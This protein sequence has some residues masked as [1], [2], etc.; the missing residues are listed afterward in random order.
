MDLR[1]AQ[2][3]ELLDEANAA[4]FDAPEALRSAWDSAQTAAWMFH[5]LQL[6]GVS[7]RADDIQ[8]ALRDEQ[9]VDYCDGVLL[10]Q[11]RRTFA[12]L[13]DVRR[14]GEDERP[15]SLPML[16]DW[17]ARL[18]GED[19]A[20]FRQS[21]GATEH[22][23]HDVG[24]PSAIIDDARVLF[25]STQ[26]RRGEDHPIPVA[27][28]LLFGL[29]KIWPYPTWS[30]MCAR[31]AASAVLIGQGYPPLVIP[32]RERVSFYQ[33]MHYDPSRMETLM[34]ACLQR[35]LE[36]KRDVMVGRATLAGLT[37]ALANEP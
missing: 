17:Q 36:A 28:D 1:F 6:E 35:Q 3:D 21:E 32:W 4:Y 33:A 2:T 14:T 9:G 18:R 12:L 25:R 26:R 19:D 29:M 13:D 11:I 37:D 7:L 5:E 22:Y 15:L 24:S 10:A 16:S 34:I 23:K 8:R 31:L 20:P 27:N 30:G